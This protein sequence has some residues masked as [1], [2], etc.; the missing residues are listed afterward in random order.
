MRTEVRR[1]LILA[2]PMIGTMV[3]RMLL[4]FTDTVM[5]AWLGTEATAA[6]SP[7]TIFIFTVICLG[8]GVAASIQTFCA[9]AH[10]RRMPRE[11]AAYA[12]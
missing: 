12:W 4:G 7:S 8:M 9:Q 5:V 6:I 3:S 1:L 11:A 10:G 2:A